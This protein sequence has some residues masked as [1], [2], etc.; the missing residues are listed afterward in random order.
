MEI[1]DIYYT[2]NNDKAIIAYGYNSSH[3]TPA[4]FILKNVRGIYWKP[5][6]NYKFIK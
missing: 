3:G 4:Y 6:D 5:I 2:E 1:Y